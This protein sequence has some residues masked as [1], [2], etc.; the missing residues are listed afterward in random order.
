MSAETHNCR[1]GAVVRRSGANRVAVAQP[2]ADARG[3][4]RRFAE[5]TAELDHDY[6]KVEADLERPVQAP[7]LWRAA[8]ARH[9]AMVAAGEAAGPPAPT[10]RATS[11]AGL[12]RSPAEE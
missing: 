7:N 12:T 8:K 5:A 4:Y 3:M 11:T 9:A 10:E 2:Q 6:A 1:C